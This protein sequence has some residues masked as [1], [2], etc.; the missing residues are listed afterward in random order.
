MAISLDIE[1]DAPVAELQNDRIL[2]IDDNPAI[3]E[4]FK[5][6]FGA[7]ERKEAALDEVEAELFGEVGLGDR[8]ATFRLDSAFQGQEGLTLI[9]RSLEANAPYA[10][11]FVD[12]RMPPGWDGIETI[13]RIWSE[14]PDLQVVVC[15][16]YSDYSWSE[17]IQKLGH[18]DRLLILKKPFDNIEVLQMAGALTEKW[19]LYRQAKSRLEDL[20]RL[21]QERTAALQSTN[22]ELTDANERVLEESRRAKELAAAALVANKS[23]SEFLATM[24]H[25]I[26]TPMNGI[27]GMTDLLLDSELDPEQRDQAQTIKQSAD[28]LLLIINDILD[29]SKIEA[30]KVDLERL[31]FNLHKITRAAIDLTQQSAL[32]KGIKLNCAIAPETPQVLHG[33]PHRLRQVL[34]NL[35]NNAIKF[36]DDGEVDVKVSSRALPDEMVEVRFEIRDTGIGLTPESQARLFQPFSQADSSTTRR[37]GGTGLGLAICQKLVDLM[38]GRIGVNSAFGCGSTFWFTVTLA[39]FSTT[40]ISS[41]DIP[42]QRTQPL[43]IGRKLRVLVVEDGPVNQRLATYQLRKLG[44]EVEIANDGRD[45]VAAWQRAHHEVILMDCHMPNMDG[46]EATRRIRQLEKENNFPP[47]RIIAMTASAMPGDREICL[48]SGMDDYVS[49]PVDMIELR[50]VLTRAAHATAPSA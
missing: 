42:T 37:F 28:A 15:T 4:D 17:M 7:S 35:I 8:Q 30:G 19:R 31:E 23:K 50:A 32:Q 9:R 13:S 25:E 6:I 26:R 46:Y 22:Q 3:H 5:K 44:C 43:E 29:F 1:R 40:G 21:V 45:G 41:P 14:Y 20:E 12:V 10:M 11:A 47:T 48:Q 49:K 36:T 2:I 18:S 33:D 38:G 27:I 39:K 34:L 16:A 24:S